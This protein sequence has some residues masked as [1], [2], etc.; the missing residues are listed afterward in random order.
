MAAQ[1][2][3]WGPEFDAKMK[4]LKDAGKPEG[5]LRTWWCREESGK[6]GDNAFMLDGKKEGTNVFKLDKGK[7]GCAYCFEMEQRTGESNVPTN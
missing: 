3:V 1:G 4:E 6:I 5:I 7:T 2:S